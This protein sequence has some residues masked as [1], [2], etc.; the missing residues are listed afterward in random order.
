MKGNLITKV[1]TLLILVA[2]GFGA[3]AF[4]TN[5]VNTL[6]AAVIGCF[7]PA[8]LI[9]GLGMLAGDTVKVKDAARIEP[10]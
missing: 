3:Y 1:A 2:I 4:A 9:V 10:K 7:A 6:W 8:L 5:Y